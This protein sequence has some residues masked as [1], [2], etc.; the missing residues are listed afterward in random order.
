MTMHRRPVGRGRLLA[1]IGA[2]VMIAGCLLPWYAFVGDLPL[3]DVR[4]FEGPGIL[5]F[6]AALATIALVTLQYATDRPVAIDRWLA[7]AFLAVVAWVGLVLWPVN[8][9]ADLRGYWPDRA[10][11]L[12]I[13]VLGTIGLSRAAFDIAHEPPRI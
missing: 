1:V 7:Y 13:S 12:W 2:V 9:A 11:G 4:A 3:R 8:L 5:V 10:P 6:L